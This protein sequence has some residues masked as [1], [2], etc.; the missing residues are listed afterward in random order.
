[1]RKFFKTMGLV[2]AGTVTA[3]VVLIVAIA[4]LAGAGSKES[5]T[6]SVT[7]MKGDN[8]PES[9]VAEWKILSD[10][11]NIH[12][13]N[14]TGSFSA[15]IRVKNLGD[16]EETVFIDIELQNKAGDLVGTLNCYSNGSLSPG[17]KTNIKCTSIDNYK[18]FNSYKYENLI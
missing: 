5:G 11:P 15:D 8:H 4:A 12:E 3:L 17:Q 2:A 6:E 16:D 9:E 7:V 18:K 13:D 1:M 14:L 10:D